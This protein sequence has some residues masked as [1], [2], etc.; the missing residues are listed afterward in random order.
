MVDHFFNAT[1]VLPEWTVRSGRAVLVKLKTLSELEAFWR[2]HRIR[3]PFAVT[4]GNNPQ[5]Q[6][7]LNRF[8]WVF[9]ATPEDVVKAVTRWDQCG[10]RARWCPWSDDSQDNAA[11]ASISPEEVAL[12]GWWVLVNYPEA[13]DQFCWDGDDRGLIFN[14]A[15]LPEHMEHQF[16]LEIFES[17]CGN[18][19]D[20]TA[21][22]SP[23]LDAYVS[24][25]QLHRSSGLDYYGCQNEQA[26][27]QVLM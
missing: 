2:S 6:D 1:T 7:L 16:Q 27:H 25:G 21:F 17:W 12:R 5:G 15:I 22:T 19:Q 18:E 24:S 9:G 3:F 14:P 4:A 13:G 11:L 10:I 20:L 23:E 26:G 8:E